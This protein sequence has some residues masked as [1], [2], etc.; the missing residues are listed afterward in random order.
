VLKSK[1]NSLKILGTLKFDKIWLTNS[2][3]HL[4]VRKNKIFIKVDQKFEIPM[5]KEI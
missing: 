3:L 5:E 4:I 1:K 2:L